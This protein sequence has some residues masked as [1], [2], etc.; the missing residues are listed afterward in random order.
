MW[1][2]WTR[3]VFA[4]C[5]MYKYTY[6]Y[7]QDIFYMRM[8]CTTLCHFARVTMN[9]DNSFLYFSLAIFCVRFIFFLS[10][11]LFRSSLALSL[12]RSFCCNSPIFVQII[13]LS[14]LQSTSKLNVCNPTKIRSHILY[15][16]YV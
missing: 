14:G 3:F 11:R 13:Q 15:Y 16:T 5:V 2:D 9:T 8:V 7:N 10:I 6:V 4:A 12:V 1:M